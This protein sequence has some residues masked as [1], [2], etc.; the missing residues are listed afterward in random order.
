MTFYSI[1]YG[2]S[3]ELFT[4]LSEVMEDLNAEWTLMLF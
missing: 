4:M 1:L 2:H 3:I